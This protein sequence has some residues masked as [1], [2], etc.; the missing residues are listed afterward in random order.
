M[1]N[2]RMYKR[3]AATNMNQHKKGKSVCDTWFLKM[4]G[5]KMTINEG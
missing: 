5:V 3:G 4:G 2:L 1:G